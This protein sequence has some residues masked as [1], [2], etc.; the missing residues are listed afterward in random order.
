MPNQAIP[1]YLPRIPAIP[2]LSEEDL[3][4]QSIMLKRQ[5]ISL[6]QHQAFMRACLIGSSNPHTTN[7]RST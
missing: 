7:T 3:K 1:C 4:R 5:G 6:E 2:K